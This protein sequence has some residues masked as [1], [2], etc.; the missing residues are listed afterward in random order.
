MLKPDDQPGLTRLRVATIKRGREPLN[1]ATLALFIQ[2]FALSLVSI[3]PLI[4]KMHG[5]S[6][7]VLEIFLLQ[8]IFATALSCLFSMALWWH[9]IHALFPLL[10]GL[11]L[12]YP[13]SP[14]FYLC[15]LVC[16]SAIYWSTFRTQVPYYPSNGQV[17]HALQNV[18][19]DHKS[20][21]VID[22]GS[23]LGGVM[24]T[25]AKVFPQSSFYGIEI[26][27]MPWA[28]SL[29]RSKW[30]KST[31]HFLYGDYQNLNFADYDVVYAYLSPAVMTRVWQKAVKEMRPG[32]LLISNEFDVID[33]PAHMTLITTDQSSKLYV[34][35]M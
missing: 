12:R 14:I 29:L 4:A 35:R 7:S 24:M 26:A 13:V 27:P 19:N 23:G 3:S 2:V 33:Q 15:A 32:S 8:A 6:I 10:V 31:A 25:L 11:M 17:A 5:Y 28:I 16:T 30:Q 34:W 22:I 9:A 1:P 20:L 21:R 18:L